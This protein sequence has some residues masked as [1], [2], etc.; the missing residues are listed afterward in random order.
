MYDMVCWCDEDACKHQRDNVV[1]NHFRSTK[2]EKCRHGNWLQLP[3][4][5]LERKV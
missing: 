1:V 3:A 5:H 4:D 2:G